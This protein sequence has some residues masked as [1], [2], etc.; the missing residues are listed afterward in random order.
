M[1]DE[2]TVKIF[3]IRSQI[4]DNKRRGYVV[5]PLTYLGKQAVRVK[6]EELEINFL[7]DPVSLADLKLRWY[8]SK[9]S[10]FISFY[11]WLLKTEV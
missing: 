6:C 5:Q 9:L 2:K 8:A 1:R 3:K 11:N 7:I 4:E 10:R